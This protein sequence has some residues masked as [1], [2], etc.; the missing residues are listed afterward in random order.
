MKKSLRA[1]CFALAV[2]TT[3]AFANAALA[4]YA[5][6]LVVASVTPQA[7]GGGGPVRIGA[8]GRERRRP[9]RPRADLRPDRLPARDA[10]GR[11]EDRRRDGD[12][13]SCRSR[14]RDP[15]AHRRAPGGRA[16]PDRRCA[17]RCRRV[18]VLE[19]RA[20]GGRPDPRTSRCTSSRRPRASRPWATRRSSSSACRRR[21]CPAGTPGRAQFGAKLLSASFGVSAITQ[22]VAS[23]DSRWTS[24]FTPYKPAKGA[25]NAA[26]TVE[27]QSV[28]HIPTQIKLNTSTKKVT[29]TKTITRKG[30]RV[31]VKLV[32]TRVTFSSTV[33]ENGQA[34]VE[35]LD[36]DD[37]RRQEGRRRDPG[38][39]S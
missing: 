17:V 25:V 39:S 15:A 24:L 35:R 36:H 22:P 11:H 38:R 28:R 27:T 26:G 20:D 10:R 4:S 37:G 12:R 13:G 16:E 31:K 5:P 33:T 29:T 8:V 7:A 30:K 3:L 34:P 19:P 2:L 1:A 9:D 14:R 21:T 6:K 32:K 18:A 23:G